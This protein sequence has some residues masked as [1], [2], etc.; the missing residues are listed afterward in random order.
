[1]GSRALQARWQALSET[2]LGTRESLA[3]LLLT[4]DVRRGL[5]DA[6][7]RML[8]GAR[9]LGIPVTVLVT[10]ADKLPRRAGE[11]GRNT[12]AAGAGVPTILF[13]ALT[14]Q[15]VDEARACLEAWLEIA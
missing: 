7:R 14:K 9:D 1:M 11:E 15:G 3:G 13:S 6:D 8:E 5:M 4:V 10:K 2:Y 12:V